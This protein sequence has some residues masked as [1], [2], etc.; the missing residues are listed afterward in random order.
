MKLELNE[1]SNLLL[2][3]LSMSYIIQD[4]TGETDGFDQRS[5]ESAMIG[6]DISIWISMDFY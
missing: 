5:A 6:D 1:I 4:G 2:I 3:Y